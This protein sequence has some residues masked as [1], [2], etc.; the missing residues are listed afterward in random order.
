MLFVPAEGDKDAGRGTATVRWRAQ[1]ESFVNANRA[2]AITTLF[3]AQPVGY[4]CNFF[5][6]NR[7][8]RQHQ[9][10]LRVL[11]SNGAS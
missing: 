1:P 2:K 7:C 11:D 8:A 5:K 6:F 4:Y 3:P 9:I 10:N